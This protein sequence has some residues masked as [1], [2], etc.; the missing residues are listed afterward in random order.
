[1]SN[2]LKEQLAN[3]RL[4]NLSKRHKKNAVWPLE[5]KIEVVSKYLIL[6]N[7][8]LVAADTGVDY[9]LVRQW[10]IQP[11]WKDLEAEIRATQNIAMDNKLSTII[12]RSM[13]ATMDRLENGE[14]I[15]NNKTGQLVRKPVSMKDAAKVATDFMTRQQVLRKEETDKPQVSQ[16]SVTEQL[17]ALAMEFAKWQKISTAKTEA[18]DVESKEIT[19]AFSEDGNPMQEMPENG[20]DVSPSDE[21]P[22]Q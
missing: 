4:G 19:D 2:T 17:A 18:V 11:W 12:E 9:G 5:K 21:L 8:K 16:Q 20:T 3:V 15:L 22:K 10:K 13:E 14:L 6:G 7:L 1:M